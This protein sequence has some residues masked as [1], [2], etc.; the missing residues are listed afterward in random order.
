MK[1]LQMD[2]IW[3]EVWQGV[4]EDFTDVPDIKV[5]TQLVLRMLLASGLGGLLGYQRERQGRAAGLR[6]HMLVALG[7]AFFVLIPLQAGM[8]LTDLS[9]VLQGLLAGIGFLAAGTILKQQATEQI[10][11]LTTAAG[12]WLTAAIGIA[13]GLGRETSAVLGTGLAFVILALL[14]QVG[15]PAAPKTRRED[16]G[17]RQEDMV[18]SHTQ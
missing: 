9:R 16:P 1:G 18:Q 5:L 14:P 7:S 13:V 2:T 8:P 10:Q 12:L 11:G 4:Q 3:H 6:T 17:A 15:P